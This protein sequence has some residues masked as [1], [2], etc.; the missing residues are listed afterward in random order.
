MSRI[1]EVNE[2]KY[3]V[4]L[5]LLDIMMRNGIISSDEYRKIDNLNRLTFMPELSKIY[6]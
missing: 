1:Q 2:V 6:A 5:K 4:T 3:K